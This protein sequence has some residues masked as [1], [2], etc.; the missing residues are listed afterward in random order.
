LDDNPYIDPEY[1]RNLAVIALRSPHRYEQLRHGNWEA[2]E[3]TFF[4]EFRASV[5]GKPYHVRQLL[6]A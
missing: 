2:T 4:G 3:G 1:E 6:A 5:D